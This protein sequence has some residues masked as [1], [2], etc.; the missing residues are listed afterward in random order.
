MHGVPLFTLYRTEQR[1]EELLRLGLS[2]SVV[3][4]ALFDL[5]HPLFNTR[6]EDL[7]PPQ[8]EWEKRQPSG[9]PVTYLW[10][11]QRYHRLVTGVRVRGSRWV[12]II[13]R[14]ASPRPRLEFILFRPDAV[15]AGHVVIA[16][17]EQGL[18]ASVFSGLIA[19]QHVLRDELIENWGDMP[20]PQEE[21]ES[22]RRKDLEA[23]AKSVGFRYLSETEAIWR[24][25]GDRDDYYD[26][27]YA[28][29]R[30][31]L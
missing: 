4:L 3:R 17:S 2:P 11:F 8:P 12:R 16:R 18:L 7:G 14:L 24:R 31:I 28:Y 25:H 29:T 1:R 21:W 15:S 10:C 23:A 6:C 13:S 30:S 22:H 20:F 19:D 9:A 5:P 27:L 26:L